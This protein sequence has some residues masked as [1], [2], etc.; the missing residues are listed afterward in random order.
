M[1]A[2]LS[3]LAGDDRAARMML[4]EPNN[5]VTGR[6]LARVGVVETLWL[7]ST[8]AL[9]WASVAH[10]WRDHFD[11][12]VVKDIASHLDQIRQSGIRALIPGDTDW[13]VVLRDLVEPYTCCGLVVLRPLLARPVYDFITITGHTNGVNRL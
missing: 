8:T 6:L 12:R 1:M 7:P 10:V 3:D 13:S 5:P 2:D 11:V 4:V 9:W